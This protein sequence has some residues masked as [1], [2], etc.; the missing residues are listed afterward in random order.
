MTI[1]E[2]IYTVLSQ[3]NI[4]VNDFTKV[5]EKHDEDHIVLHHKTRIL[6]SLLKIIE[7]I[8]ALKES[9]SLNSNFDIDTIFK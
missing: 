7:R 1:M 4:N 5:F 2:E 3:K 8:D 9:D 6:W